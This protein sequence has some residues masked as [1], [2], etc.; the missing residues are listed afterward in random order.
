MPQAHST[1][2]LRLWVPVVVFAHVFAA[3]WFIKLFLLTDSNALRSLSR[4]RRRTSQCHL[5][6]QRVSEND[7]GRVGSDDVV[8]SMTSGEPIWAAGGA[9]HCAWGGGGSWRRGAP[10][11][12]APMLACATAALAMRCALAAAALLAEQATHCPTNHWPCAAPPSQH[13]AQQPQHQQRSPRPSW[14]R[15]ATL[16]RRAA[17]TWRWSACTWSG[18]PS[19]APTTRRPTRSWC[20]KTSGARRCL[21]RCRCARVPP[22]MGA[23]LGG[24]RGGRRRGREA[25]RAARSCLRRP[26]VSQQASGSSS[27]SSGSWGVPAC[28]QCSRSS[29]LWGCTGAPTCVR[30]IAHTR[31]ATLPASTLPSPPPQTHTHTQALLGPSGAGKSTLMDI[32][33][34]R[35]SMGNLSGYLLVDGQPATSSFI[36]KTA[37]VPQVR[38]AVCG[39][40]GR[41]GRSC[42][43]ALL[44]GRWLHAAARAARAWAVACRPLPRSHAPGPHPAR[45]ARPPTPRA[46]PPRHTNRRTTLWRR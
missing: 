46:S 36:R 22:E 28:P 3:F 10:S 6:K 1:A 2:I 15:M 44:Q 17:W 43:A 19:A 25:A 29:Q 38:L 45:A 7:D 30:I 33:A 5:P 20:C 21:G 32:M 16:P 39:G 23:K 9:L 11:A 12:G 41:G 24:A 8:L 35:K 42:M 4:R 40:G 31:P 26:R 37:Y 14:T 13:H 18:R 27:S 34:Q